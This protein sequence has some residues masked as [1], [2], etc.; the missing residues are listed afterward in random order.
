L[1]RNTLIGNAGS[2]PVA[3][4]RWR[5]PQPFPNDVF[6]V[7]K[8]I[9]AAPDVTLG[10]GDVLALRAGFDAYDIVAHDRAAV[11]FVLGGQSALPLAWTYRRHTRLPVAAQ[12]VDRA[13]LRIRQLLAFSD[14]LADASLVPAIAALADHPSHFVRWAAGVS[15]ARLA[16]TAAA[17]FLRGL[18][19]DPHPHVRAAAQHLLSERGAR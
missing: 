15:T 16:P 11:L 18:A 4:R 5:Q 3:I 1:T 14:A 7:A 10:S 17:P 19:G 6:D 9:E 8:T 12:P 13:W 2:A